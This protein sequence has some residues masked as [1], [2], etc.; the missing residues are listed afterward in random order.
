MGKL[1]VAVIVG[2]NRQDSI[3]RRLAEALVRLGAGRMDAR[4]VRIDDL[5]LYNQDLEY[6]R[7]AAVQRFTEE[8]A[9]A[10]ALLIVTPE[11]NRSITAV[12]KN[13]IDWGAWSM[14]DN[15]W[16]G[17]AAAITGAS[18]G[19]MGA[20]AGQHH[21]RHI[22]GALGAVVV[23]GEAYVSFRPDLIDDAGEISNARIR[24]RLAAYVED[25]LDLAQ[26]LHP[27]AERPRRALTPV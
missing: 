22:L 26:R 1:A 13:A 6:A 24:A 20:S 19:A 3:N 4:F 21:L 14:D 2:S 27:H 25:F 5:P 23:G 17:K 10:D 9:G 15:V 7:P 16:K 11:H 8:V 18:P 12:L